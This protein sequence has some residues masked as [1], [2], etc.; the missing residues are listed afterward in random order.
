MAPAIRRGPFLFFFLFLCVVDI[1]EL[2]ILDLSRG[3]DDVLVGQHALP[4]ELGDAG[5][6]LLNVA[7]GGGDPLAQGGIGRLGCAPLLGVI[8]LADLQIGLTDGVLLAGI[9]QGQLGDLHQLLG[10]GHTG[11]AQIR[12]LVSQ[13]VDK[14][15]TTCLLAVYSAD[16]ILIPFPDIRKGSPSDFTQ[17]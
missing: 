16:I 8:E 4:L 5:L 11:P 6:V 2:S 13:F 15:H 12:R 14:S 3:L 10:L 7:A 17:I 1:L 9:V